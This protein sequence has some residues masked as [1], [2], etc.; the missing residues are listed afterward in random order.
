MICSKENILRMSPFLDLHVILFP[1]SE[2]QTYSDV[3][4]KSEF[5]VEAIH[6]RHPRC[7][8]PHFPHFP[9]PP[10]H[11]ARHRRKYRPYPSPAVSND[12]TRFRDDAVGDS[13]PRED[14]VQ[15]RLSRFDAASTRVD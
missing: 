11:L 10:V 15:A 8:C 3:F 9:L 5:G 7:L 12:K 6:D 2:G 13:D 4:L 14:M 1:N